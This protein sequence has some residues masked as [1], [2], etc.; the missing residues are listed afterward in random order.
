MKLKDYEE[1]LKAR[2]KEAEDIQEKLVTPAFKEQY[3]MEEL[4][5]RWALKNFQYLFSEELKNEKDA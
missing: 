4:A 1:F 2:I 3:R 5:Y